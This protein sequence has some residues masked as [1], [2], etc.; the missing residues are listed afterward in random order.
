M[1][2]PKNAQPEPMPWQAVEDGNR[3]Q[4]LGELEQTYLERLKDEAEAKEAYLQARRASAKA[5][6]EVHR[7]ARSITERLPLFDGP[8]VA[9]DPGPGWRKLPVAGVKGLTSAMVR[10]LTDA[11]LTTVG[12]V[13]DR[14]DQGPALADVPGLGG[15]LAAKV[16]QEIERVRGQAAASEST[17]EE[18]DDE[19]EDETQ[20]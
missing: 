15:C 8:Q 3:L 10:A 19:H 4:R 14:I 5:S 16:R 13:A 17:P 1:T 18:P 2:K 6:E 20:A 12:A 9:G 7:Y 11:N